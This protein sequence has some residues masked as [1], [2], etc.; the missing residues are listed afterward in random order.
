MKVHCTTLLAAASIAVSCAMVACGSLETSSEDATDGAGS[1]TT[2]ARSGDQVWPRFEGMRGA[3]YCEVLLA[4]V[5]DGRLNAEVWN[6][7][8]LNDCPQEDWDALDA[9]A[10]K[11]EREVLVALTNGPRYFLMDAIERQPS[12][13]PVVTSFGPLE[14]S[15]VATVDLGPIPPDLSA[16]TERKVRRGTVF[17]FNAGAEVYE[18]RD[19]DGRVFVMQSY[20]TQI[21]PLLNEEGLASLGSRLSLPDGWSYS[22]RS[23]D[24]P[25][26]VAFTGPE[27]TVIQDD[28]GNVYSLLED[29]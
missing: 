8:G 17:E 27:A 23:L 22:A 18:L 9:A 14:M 16:Y 24:G 6:T 7:Y 12:G 15:L 28:L 20:S 21:D 5:V 10:I 13:E 2:S 3:R 29:S 4:Q 26:R 11:T 19:P 1:S 25:L